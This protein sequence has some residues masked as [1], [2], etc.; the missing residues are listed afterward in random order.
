MDSSSI[1]STLGNLS[2]SDKSL[3][4]EFSETDRA[5]AAV[6]SATIKDVPKSALEEVFSAIDFVQLLGMR[7]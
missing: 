4:A 6:A 1:A 7:R 3:E 2:V 5:L